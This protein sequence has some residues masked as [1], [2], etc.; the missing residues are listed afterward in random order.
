MKNPKAYPYNFLVLTGGEEISRESAE[1][2]GK[3]IS[4]KDAG[5]TLLDYFAGQALSD[6]ESLYKTLQLRGI[7][8]SHANVADMAYDLA[9]SM[10]KEREKRNVL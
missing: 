1:E 6:V 5:M 8:T 2:F 7:D 9:E 3:H 4:K 10:L